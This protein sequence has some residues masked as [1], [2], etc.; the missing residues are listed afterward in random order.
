MTFHFY[1]GTHQPHWLWKHPQI[2]WFVS[3]TTLRR[4]RGFGRAGSPWALDSGGYSELHKYGRWTVTPAMYAKRVRLYQVEIGNLVWAAPQ[5]WMCEDTSLLATGSTVDQHQ[6]RTTDSYFELMSMGVPTIPVLQ[7]RTVADYRKHLD[8]YVR[9]GAGTSSV[10][11]LGSVCRRQAIKEIQD[12]IQSLSSAGLRIHAFGFKKTGLRTCWSSLSSSDSL[13]WSFA[14]RRL[15]ARA[16][17]CKEHHKNCANCFL[18]AT[19]WRASLLNS[20][21]ISQ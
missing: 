11:G 3:D 13:A 21:G 15:S 12:L 2:S 5:D 1:T 19:Q 14:A 20:L 7:G 10:Y 9:R 18:Y 8:E 16:D 17:G 6:V 4:R